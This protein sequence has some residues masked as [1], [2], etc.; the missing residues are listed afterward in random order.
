[1]PPGGSHATI[2]GMSLPTVAV[3]GRPNV[4]K[5]TFTNRLVGR[6][7]AIVHDEPGVTRDRLYLKADWNGRDFVVVDTGGIVPHEQAD[8]IVASIRDQAAAAIEHADFIFMVVDARA[9]LTPADEEIAALLRPAGKPVFLVA[10]KVDHIGLESETSEFYRLGF[11]Q[12]WGVSAIHGLGVGDLLD[13]LVNKFPPEGEKPTEEGLRIAL[14]GRPN[15]GKSSLTNRLLGEHR[16]IVS[17]IAGTTR[18][19]IDTPFQYH[20][21]RY[22]LVDTAGVRRKAKVDYGVEAF[23]VVRALKAMERADVVILV[24]DAT[25]GITDQDQR[26][27]G[28]AADAGKPLL[29]AVNKW[30]LVPKDGHTMSSFEEG[31]REQLPHA[32]FATIRFTSALT[33]QRVQRLIEDAEAAA[34]QAA[35][36]VT[37]GV[38]NEVLTEAMAMTSP[39]SRRGRAMK[40]YFATQARTNP[41]TFVLF[42]NDPDLVPDSY[43]R[44]LEKQV[45]ASF[46]F[47]GTPVRLLFRSRRDKDGPGR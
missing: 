30:D 17:P 44:Y 21:K 6:R 16:M 7:E 2:E 18:D 24:I 39:P 35:R 32:T 10:N 1:M 23:A 40:L 46:G 13:E 27:V 19:A 29:L 20:G 47:E 22:W 25:V 37:T 11:G 15:A 3:V 5:S 31:L 38:L 12:P 43:A 36:R 9:G 4:G 14:V 34:E 45:R 8:E 41:P 26:L 33:G 42:V 28:M